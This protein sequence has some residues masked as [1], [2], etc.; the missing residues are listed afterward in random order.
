MP[1]D[2]RG[3][4]F[5]ADV[6]MDEPGGVRLASAPQICTSTWRTRAAGCGR[7]LHELV[8]RDAVEVLH[9]VVEQ[10]SGVCP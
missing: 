4:T 5:A 9:R 6:A 1:R 3:I 2:R 10:P 7:R 8:E